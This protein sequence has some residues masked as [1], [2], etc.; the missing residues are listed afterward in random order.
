M[1]EHCRQ[2][3][4]GI[5]VVCVLESEAAHVEYEDPERRIAKGQDNARSHQPQFMLKSVA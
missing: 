4:K 2:Y 5:Q 1:A 3:A